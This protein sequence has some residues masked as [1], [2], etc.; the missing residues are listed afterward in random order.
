[1]KTSRR[2]LLAAPGVLLLPMMPG[3]PT[4]AAAVG[5]E[6]RLVPTPE[7]SEGPFYPERWEGDVDGD[8]LT[9]D[10]RRHERGLPLLIG[11]RVL[12]V[13]GVPLAGATVE[14]WQADTE[15]QYRHSRDGRDAPLRRGFQG[16]GRVRTDAEGRYRLRTLKPPAYG[17]RP[18]H[19]HFRVRAEGRR[20]LTTQMYF[21]GENAERSLWG[22]FSRERER[23]TVTLAEARDEGRPA[24]AATF[25]LV[26]A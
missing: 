20:V 7:D 10:G 21:A 22:G 12:A 6:R 9:L 18:P 26:L 15:G 24:V 23:L 19:V 3:L 2:R 4:P 14:I 5:S 8:L 13:D 16:F 25:D 1:M 17:G 11:G